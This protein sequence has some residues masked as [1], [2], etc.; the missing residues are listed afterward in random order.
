MGSH[1][2]TCHPA[3][4]I[5]LPLRQPKL[6]LDWATPEGCK[7]A[8]ASCLVHPVYWTVRY[9]S[10]LGCHRWVTD[11]WHNRVWQWH[12]TMRR[13][14]MSHVNVIIKLLSQLVPTERRQVHLHN[15]TQLAGYI[16]YQNLKK[17]YVT[18]IHSQCQSQT[19]MNC[20]LVH[21]FR[22]MMGQGKLPQTSALPPNVTRNNRHIGA[23]RSLQNMPK[24]VSG[25]G[26]APN[27][28]GGA[29]DAP[30]TS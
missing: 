10:Q 9:L 28:D 15:S 4:V 16:R 13:I 14:Q 20:W 7:T 30:Q 1:S 19:S 21:I 26:S 27:P 11:S 3:A 18:H 23:K 5:F 2:V 29:N 8:Q 24:Y 6:V 22:P 12:V 17:L 25:R